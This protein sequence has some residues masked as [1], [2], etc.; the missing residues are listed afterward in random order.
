MSKK[1]DL[2]GKLLSFADNSVTLIRKIS[3]TKNCQIFLTDCNSIVKSYSLTT[4]GFNYFTREIP[5]YQIVSPHPNI[6]EYKDHILINGQ[7]F[8]HLEYYSKGDYNYILALNRLSYPEIIEVIIDV[9]I[10]LDDLHGKGILHLDLRPENILASN[11]GINK[12]CDFGSSLRS[13]I[14]SVLDE[15]GKM[16]EFISENIFHTILPPELKGFS[17]ATVGPFTDMWQ[18]GCLIYLM[19]FYKPAFP[20]GYSQTIILEKI[21]NKVLQ[22]VLDS[23]LQ[24]N[25]LNRPSARDVIDMLIP[26][27]IFG[28]IL[29]EKRVSLFE[30]LASKSTKQLVSRII[31]DSNERISAN[32]IDSL[33]YKG[34]KKPFKIK[35]VL[36]CMEETKIDTLTQSLKVLHLLHI[37]MYKVQAVVENHKVLI[38]KLLRN[39]VYF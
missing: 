6:A 38:Y 34:L 3:E 29:S 15:S 10:A 14:L 35:K 33:I 31:N 17:S 16:N 12:L 32:A 26:S 21:D 37:Y 19:T 8:L 9:C 23:L 22:R 4:S 24:T 39:L 18:L 25:P 7:A 36:S 2:Q 5:V 1:N 11:E 30:K 20:Y 28:N 27:P 13:E